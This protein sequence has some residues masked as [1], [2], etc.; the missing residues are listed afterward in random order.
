[1]QRE[2]ANAPQRS[3]EILDQIAIEIVP[4]R[5]GCR[6]R[7]RGDFDLRASG[8]LERTLTFVDASRP[9]RLVIDVRRLGALS[10]LAA[11]HLFHAYR[12]LRRRGSE[13]VLL[14][15]CPRLAQMLRD[16]REPGGAQPSA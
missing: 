7:L 1:M 10:A 5:E 13:T 14:G 11:G 9:R 16:E 6:L 8:V 12:G 3:E 4:T 15:D 2:Y